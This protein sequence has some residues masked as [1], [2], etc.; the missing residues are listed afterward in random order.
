MHINVLFS[1]SIQNFFFF[2]SSQ[3]VYFPYNFSACVWYI[4]M[5]FFFLHE[6]ANKAQK[7]QVPFFETHSGFESFWQCVA[8]F[9]N[10]LQYFAMCCDVFAAFCIFLQCVAVCCSVLQYVVIF[11]SVLQCVAVCC[12]VLHCVA[13][14]CNVLQCFAMC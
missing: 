9:C 1:I 5:Y 13:V 7:Q 12:T 14:F 3:L 6:H 11:C 8:V 2:G 10:L 4:Y